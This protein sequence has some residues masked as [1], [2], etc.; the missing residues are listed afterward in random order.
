MAEDSV[1]SAAARRGLETFSDVAAPPA[2]D[3]TTDVSVVVRPTAR[4][5]GVRT[6]EAVAAVT[7][8]FAT[9][10]AASGACRRGAAATLSE[11]DAGGAVDGDRG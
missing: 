8:S 7:N 4:L 10:W 1:W 9:D 3:E 6:G 11:G 2:D 5:A